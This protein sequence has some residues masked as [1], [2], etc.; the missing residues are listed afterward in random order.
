[1]YMKK[2]ICSLF[3]ILILISLSGCKLINK[4]T[5]S[6]SSSSDGSEIDTIDSTDLFNNK[7][8][9]DTVDTTDSVLSNDSL[10]IIEAGSYI[11]SDTVNGTITVNVNNKEKVTITLDNVTL[12]TTGFASIYIVSADKVYI[13]LVGVNTI[14]NTGSYTQID[15]NNVDGAIFSKTDLSIIGT[16]SLN[17][18]S[19]SHGI[20]CK[21]DLVLTNNTINITSQDRGI[22]ANDSL[23]TLNETLTINSSSDG[24]HV[25][26]E[27]DTSKGN[28]YLENTN[29]T[30]TSGM[31]GISS[32]NILE[33]V[34]GVYNLTCTSSYSI[35]NRS[36]KGLKAKT[37]IIIKAE[38]ITINSKDDSIHSNDNIL[39]E[40]GT[41]TLSSNDD[42]I[43][44]DTLLVI[45]DSTIT[46]TK[47]YE[48]L[49]A[50]EIDINGGNI[51]I[52]SSD[53]GL[54]AA[55]G[56]DQSSF[57]GR[58]G[59]NTFNTSS[60]AKINITGGTLLV[61]ASGD[62]IDSNGT[63]TM[64]GGNVLVYGPTDSGNGALDYDSSFTIT[65]GTLCAIGSSGMAQN[66]SSATQGSILYNLSSTKSSNVSIKL[67]YNNEVIY[68]TTSIKTF[69]SIVISTPNITKG[70]TYK[71][72]IGTTEYSIT[73][74]N[75]IYGTSSQMGG[76]G[77]P[78]G[79][80]PGGRR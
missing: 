57:S 20:V 72:C 38:T 76:G 55:G 36:M 9:S 28:I 33:I 16:G 29:I 56:N 30:L 47:S 8:L 4:N 17:I 22:D 68:E 37:N 59:Q 66:V 52:T 31:D 50:N 60:N 5:E 46:I 67:K 1:M 10:T 32:S 49:E 13:N 19:A 78:G 58:P 51:S 7:E 18:T 40:K 75:Y 14:N 34:N 6:S 3:I 44:A 69:N 43:H 15:S 2:K 54:N 70:N 25:E 48:G 62:G 71:L 27:D 11:F 74:S 24:I 45:N 35:S 63:I 12:N 64:S 41:L 79:G 39:I 65:G 23:S 77:G 61:K 73:M 80:G 21:D 53:D 26:N 42:G